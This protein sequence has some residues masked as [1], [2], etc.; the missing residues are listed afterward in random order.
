MGKVLVEKLL[1]SCP[2]VKSIYILLRTKKNVDPR[3]R[4]DEL[5]RSKIFD[6]VREM[7][8]SLLDKVIVIPGDIVLPGLGISDSYIELISQEVSIVFHSAATVKFDEP[9]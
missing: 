3:T 2:N 1:R 4:L 8:A 6:R 9:M 5:I 7:N